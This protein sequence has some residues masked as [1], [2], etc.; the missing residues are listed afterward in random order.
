[1]NIMEWKKELLTKIEFENISNREKKE[2]IAK[3]IAEKVKDG[4]IIGFGSGSTSYLAA[5]E[6]AKVI[7]QKN[8]NI[9]AIPTSYEMKLLCS[10]YNIKTCSL[11]EKKPDWSFD[12]A[13]EVDKND[14]LI[15]GRGGAMFKEKLN[16]VNSKITY[17]LI[18]ESKVV[19][20]LGSKFSIPVECY[21]DSLNYV[22]EELIMLGAKQV[23]IRKAIAKDGPIFTENNN[24]ILDAKFEQIEEHLEKDIKSITGVVESGLFIG[25]NVQILK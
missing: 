11:L 8:I 10:S 3:R 18:D 7:K 19:D 15:K 2:I 22:K 6:I 25:Y 5:I 17:I 13:D 14:W 23:E 16:M 21:S 4:D 24:I 1:M 20:K 12:G 9:T